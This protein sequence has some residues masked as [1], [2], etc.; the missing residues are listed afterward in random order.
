MVNTKFLADNLIKEG[1]KLTLRSE[2]NVVSFTHPKIQ[3]DQLAKIL[4]DKGWM[5]SVSKCPKAIRII[6]MPHIKQ[7]H[8]LDF[9]SCLCEIKNA[10]GII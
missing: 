5:I 10:L 4:E 8:L 2:L 6:L 1:F 9:L 7:N 3:T